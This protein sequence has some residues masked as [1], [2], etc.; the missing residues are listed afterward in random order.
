M[1][2]KKL[3]ILISGASTGIGFAT[4]E[5]LAKEGHTVFAGIRNKNIVFKV[6]NVVPIILDVA[7][8]D[9]IKTALD[10]I[11]KQTDNKLDVLMNNAGIAVG[12]P[13]EAVG[14]D[15][16]KKQFEVNVFGLYE[17]TRQA[18]PALRAN[19]NSKIIN[20]SSVAGLFATPFMGP[21]CSSKFAVEAMSDTWRRELE[22][23]GIKVILLEP[24]PIATPIW[25]KSITKV[26]ELEYS[27]I[28]E[29]YEP[30]LLLF[31][32]FVKN[33][34]AGAVPVSH[35]TDIVL[36]IIKTKNPKARY[37]INGRKNLL[38]LFAVLPEKWV[39]ALIKKQFSLRR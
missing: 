17:L 32:K 37:I 35:L 20:V 12:G 21:Y 31:L 1:Q 27:K 11:L 28:A 34:A 4:A 30:E 5:A 22:K 38:K 36:D 33:E 25:E 6:S 7:S 15:A 14:L 8:E 19:S 9:S 26:P 29:L 2:N 23:F 10:E 39:D 24:G 18:L 16:I 13:L 3:K